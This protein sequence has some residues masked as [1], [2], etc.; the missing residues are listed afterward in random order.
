MSLPCVQQPS[1]LTPART[2]ST[3]LLPFQPTRRQPPSPPIKLK[4]QP[5]EARELEGARQD[6]RP[7]RLDRGSIEGRS[8][9]DGQAW[10]CATSG[11]QDGFRSGR[12]HCPECQE[13][14]RPV[15]PRVPR[16]S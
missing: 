9:D 6:L 11:D 4:E 3:L 14:G 13:D 10:Y 1:R 2:P 16:A 8:P 15:E 5:S 7:G 12:G